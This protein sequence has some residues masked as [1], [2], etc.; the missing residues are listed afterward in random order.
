M[1]NWKSRLNTDHW[2]KKIVILALLIAVLFIIFVRTYERFV[3]PVIQ[4][5]PKEFYINDTSEESVCI[6]LKDGMV[7]QTVEGDY[8]GLGAFAIKFAVTEISGD[9]QVLVRFRDLKDSGVVFESR[10]PVSELADLQFRKFLFANDLEDVVN[11]TYKIE[12]SLNGKADVSLVASK[13]NAYASGECCQNKKTFEG[14]LNFSLFG[15]SYFFIQGVYYAAGI[16]FIFLVVLI[17]AYLAF[18][19]KIKLEN[20]FLAASLVFGIAYSIVL[21]PFATPDESA[22]FISSYNISSSMLGREKISEEDRVTQDPYENDGYFNR[23]IDFETY[24]YV[25]NSFHSSDQSFLSFYDKQ[26]NY[27]EGKSLFGGH[28]VQAVAISIGRLAGFNYMQLAYFVRFLNLVFYCVV[29]Y[30]AVR[31]VPIGKL[32]MLCILFLPM[33]FE[34]A[35]SISYDGWVISFGFLYIA[36]CLRCI[37]VKER[38]N[39]KDMLLLFFLLYLCSNF[40]YVYYIMGGLLLLIPKE[41]YANRKQQYLLLGIFAAFFLLLAGKM[42]VER[43]QP[44]TQE[45]IEQ[46]EAE[47]K[48]VGSVRGQTYLLSDLLRHPKT[49]FTVYINTARDSFGGYL[50]QMLGASLGS[51]NIAVNSLYIYLLLIVL[52]LSAFPV[53]IEQNTINR[54]QVWVYA[55]VLCG[56]GAA[57]LLSMLVAWTGITEDTIVGVQGRYLIPVLPLA[58]LLIGKLPVHIEK[59]ISKKIICLMLL[60]NF[61]VVFDVFEFCIRSR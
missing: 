54:N 56:V 15:S 55:A 42:I 2:E 60:I 23:Y 49:L 18:W 41:K 46:A 43:S 30:F 12:I 39:L 3:L 37:Y 58:G 34:L 5:E 28:F 19:K 36:Y 10:I 1:D 57:I 26:Y 6:P 17:F 53:P 50:G 59:D 14:D 61:F 8:N 16:S 33:V 47:E 29:G 7:S 44:V 52:F 13:E 40:K 31:I 9:S 45:Q 25:Y 24:R 51:L 11:H 35:A 27:I 21:P 4:E 48:V 20:V 38:V 22:H 32:F